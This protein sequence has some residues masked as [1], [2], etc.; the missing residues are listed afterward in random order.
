MGVCIVPKI[1]WILKGK[2]RLDVFLLEVHV[3]S[4]MIDPFSTQR[5]VLE[6]SKEGSIDKPLRP[7][8]DLSTMSNDWRKFWMEFENSLYL[9]RRL[10]KKSYIYFIRM[11]G[12]RVCI[13]SHFKQCFISIQ[14][15]W[16]LFCFVFF[17]ISLI[18]WSFLNLF[19]YFIH[20]FQIGIFILFLK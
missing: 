10:E 4:G 15:V 6:S 18:H 9:W 2:I 17:L 7:F 13:C 5:K 1:E 14:M 12:F 20:L 3:P 19:I 11:G 16:F 8:K